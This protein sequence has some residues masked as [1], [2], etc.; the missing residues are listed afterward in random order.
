MASTA[1]A[2][3]DNDEEDRSSRRDGS[4]L[5]CSGNGGARD[6]RPHRLATV[7]LASRR[8]AEE[9]DVEEARAALSLIEARGFA[10]ERRLVE[11]FEALLRDERGPEQPAR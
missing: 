8:E 5:A 3:D 9:A 6:V 4:R 10:R 2:H 11:S 7:R 1:S